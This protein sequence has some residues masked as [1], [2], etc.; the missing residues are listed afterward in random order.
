MRGRREKKE[1]LNKLGDKVEAWRKMRAK[2][3][4]RG[5]RDGGTSNAIQ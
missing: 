2:G 1:R 3:R 4:S 5:R